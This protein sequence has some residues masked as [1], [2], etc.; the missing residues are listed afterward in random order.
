VRAFIDTSSLAKRYVQ[1]PGSEELEEFIRSVVEDIFI[2]T[3]AIVEFSAA[4]G[5]K[6]RNKDIMENEG[7]NAMQ[8]FE[9]DWQGWF[10]KVPI[11]EELA[12]FASSLA[13]Q[14]PLKGSDAVHLGS[15]ATS[16]ADLF[17]TSDVNLLK[18]AK[19]IGMQSYNP[20]TGF[21]PL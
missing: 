11:T 9:E 4:I 8:E 1:E 12:E 17:V 16:G 2:S 15:A 19:K 6:I 13:I 7:A 3:L 20:V 18:T 21:Y 5:R 14:H 10:T